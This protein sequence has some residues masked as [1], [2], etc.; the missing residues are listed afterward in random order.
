MWEGNGKSVR[1]TGLKT[2]PSQPRESSAGVTH[3]ERATS[4]GVCSLLLLQLQF[5]YKASQVLSHQRRKKGWTPAGPRGAGWG[6]RSLASPEAAFRCLAVSGQHP[7]L[8]LQP[9]LP[10]APCGQ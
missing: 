4:A 7:L 10:A 2:K 9:L 8:P 1:R 3:T 5:S 6:Q